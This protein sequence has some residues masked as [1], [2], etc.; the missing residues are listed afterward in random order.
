MS[1][2][3]TPVRISFFGGGTDLPI[4]FD[5]NDDAGVIS[6]TIDKYC[7]ISVRELPPYFEHKYRLCYS[8]IEHFNKINE[9]KHPSARAILNLFE[10]KSGLE[11]HYDGDVPARSGL[12]SSS[13]F[14]VGLL[15][16]LNTYYNIPKNP[17]ELT[18]QAL[19]VEQEILKEAVGSQDQVAVSYGGFNEV[20]FSRNKKIIV[21]KIA[22]SNENR[23]KLQNSCL[24]FYTGIQR[25]AVNIEKDKINNVKSIINNLKM[26]A[27]IRLSASKL[28]K[29]TDLNIKKIGTLLNETWNEKKQ[30][31]KSV[32]ASS[33][34]EAYEEAMNCGAYGGKLLGA[35]GGGFMLFIA[36][37]SKHS[38]IEE[39]LKSYVR[40]KFKFE[41]YGSQIIFNSNNGI[42]VNE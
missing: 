38:L 19:Y 24:L 4:Y 31:S 26:I 32:S 3:K 15:N 10:D 22:L 12:G 8:Q 25:Y 18:E 13:A 23:H 17:V 2:S 7:Y 42:I 21:N 11:M 20:M 14:T 5:N 16:A 36:P 28:F 33:I 37:E 30:L 6:T 9:I 41:E 40:I 39:R 34:N 27:D 35:G 29:E 1:I